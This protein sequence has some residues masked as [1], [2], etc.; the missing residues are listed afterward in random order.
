MVTMLSVAS[1]IGLV[2][3]HDDRLTDH[4]GH[5]LHR[6]CGTVE[7]NG[8]LLAQDP[9]WAANLTL[10]EERWRARQSSILSGERLEQRSITIPVV[11]HIVAPDPWSIP[12]SAI[13]FQLQVLQDDFSANNNDFESGVPEE[14]HPVRSGDTGIRFY[15]QNVLRVSTNVPSFGV[16]NAI[17]FSSEGGSDVVDPEHNLNF[18]AGILS[19]GLLGYAQ[20]PGG[21]PLTD[22]VVQGL[23]TLSPE[24]GSP[25]YNLG[26]TG[27]H[28]IGHWL[29]LRHIWGD[30]SG[31]TN[32]QVISDFVV[33]T[34][35]SSSANFGCP[36]GIKRC[37][38]NPYSQ[39]MMVNFMDYVEDSCM[40]M[41]TQ[42]Q[43][44]RAQESIL[45]FR[46]GFMDGDDAVT[47]RRFVNWIYFT[48]H[49]GSMD[50]ELREN[51]NVRKCVGDD[52]LFYDGD[53]NAESGSDIAIF[54]CLTMSDRKA[55]DHVVDI[56]V[57]V[58]GECGSGYLRASQDL[59]AGNERPL[60]VC[61]KKASSRGGLGDEAVL[62]LNVM[63][64]G[65]FSEFT[66]LD[67]D[68]WIT[69]DGNV[70]PDGV[71]LEL[72]MRR[73][74]DS[75]RIPIDDI[76]GNMDAVI[77]NGDDLE[78]LDEA[79]GDQMEQDIFVGVGV[80]AAAVSVVVM[81]LCIWKYVCSQKGMRQYL[82]DSLNDTFAASL[83]HGELS[84]AQ[85]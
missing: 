48:K 52:I 47:D 40:C 28:E 9:E 6:G 36:L 63:K 55:V 39:D 18:W 27:T 10:F 69:I 3:G 84:S 77:G 35:P 53:L 29:N 41:W 24:I 50:G 5:Y 11:F 33:D 4:H 62:D 67:G 25:P 31:C 42:L 66:N 82:A 20:F 32:N 56:A 81:G 21:N 37:A 17:K 46:G 74:S 83:G 80:F 85:M 73:A 60:F 34:P 43:N 2:Y 75:K 59:N 26:R 38:A 78:D 61:F 19:G 8:A 16:N 57:S 71:R 68:Q 23:G 1:L 12:D 64:E 76:D 72:I 79:E 70:N 14:F 65:D 30:N 22:G 44:A 51:G 13:A 58:D 7:Y 15:T 49:D 45:E 54:G